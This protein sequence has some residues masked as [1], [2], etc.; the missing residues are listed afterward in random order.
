MFT[1]PIAVSL[2]RKRKRREARGSTYRLRPVP[3]AVVVQSPQDGAFRLMQHL[4]LRV[5]GGGSGGGGSEVLLATAAQIGGDAVL[6][7]I[8]VYP[9]RGHY[10][11]GLRRYPSRAEETKTT[12]S[13]Y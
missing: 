7:I 10:R 13:T 2:E 8:L 4:G 6:L 11:R 12:A 5:H 3:R 9:E 1:M